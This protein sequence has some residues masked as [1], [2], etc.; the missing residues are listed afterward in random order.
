VVIIVALA[1]A[2]FYFVGRHRSVKAQQ[3]ATGILDSKSGAGGQ[4]SPIN[5]PSELVHGPGGMVYVPVQASEF[6]RISIPPVYGSSDPS[7]QRQ[8][9]PT[10]Q[11][12]SGINPRF[13]S[14]WYVA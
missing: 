13:V 1:A 7:Q 6:H 4:A 14:K 5:P 11:S 8:S 9:T 10:T 2:L 12:A 3:I